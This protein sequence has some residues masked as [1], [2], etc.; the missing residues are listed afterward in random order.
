MPP[1]PDRAP[2]RGVPRAVRARAL[3]CP[4]GVRAR[5]DDPSRGAHAELAH[6]CDDAALRQDRAGLEPDWLRLTPARWGCLAL[7][8]DATRAPTSTLSVAGTYR[9]A[10]P[11][12]PDRGTH[13][14]AGAFP[15][16][17]WCPAPGSAVGARRARA[18]AG[19]Q[20]VTR[21]GSPRPSRPDRGP[22]LIQRPTSEPHR[23]VGRLRRSARAGRPRGAA[24]RA[25]R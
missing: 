5:G 14:I 15:P 13:F 12:V 11:P 8:A 1:D 6:G 10:G 17:E 23:H 18:R 9:R 2:P 16:A 7:Y 21:L 25:C 4:D 20:R 19:C 3:A 24:C 22:R